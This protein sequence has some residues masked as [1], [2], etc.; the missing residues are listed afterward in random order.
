MSCALKE[1]LE[2][3]LQPRMRVVIFIKLWKNYCPQMETN[4]YPSHHGY[5]SL[6]RWY[7]EW[8]HPVVI[9]VKQFHPGSYPGINQYLTI[10]HRT[11]S[12]QGGNYRQHNPSHT[13]NEATNALWKTNPCSLVP[14]TVGTAAFT[15]VVSLGGHQYNPGD[16]ILYQ[17]LY[18]LQMK[19]HGN[20]LVSRWAVDE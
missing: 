20:I 16:F 4:K 5:H 11:Q 19:T 15:A 3:L 6:V 18:F 2:N 14:I 12:I 13:I 8:I 7:L 9:P 17:L 10:A 1:N